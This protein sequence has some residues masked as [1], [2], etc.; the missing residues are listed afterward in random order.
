MPPLAD[1]G[2][3]RGQ[4]LLSLTQSTALLVFSNVLGALAHLTSATTTMITCAAIVSAAALT[5]A[6][7]PAIRTVQQPAS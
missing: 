7:I 5:A 1:P 3:R 6:F 2:E 4:A